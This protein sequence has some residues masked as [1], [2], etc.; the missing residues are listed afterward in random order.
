LL[1]VSQLFDNGRK[2]V[3]SLTYLSVAAVNGV[4]S[5]RFTHRSKV[6]VAAKSV[7]RWV[8]ENAPLRQIASLDASRTSTSFVPPDGKRNNDH[9]ERQSKMESPD[10]RKFTSSARFPR[11]TGISDRW[12]SMIC[13][14]AV[15]GD[16]SRQGALRFHKPTW[17]NESKRDRSEHRGREEMCRRAVE[18]D[19][20]PRRQL[21]IGVN[22]RRQC[23]RDG[24][25]TVGGASLGPDRLKPREES[26]VGRAQAV[27][28][29]D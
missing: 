6:L 12:S 24:G 20:S 4:E 15:L 7:C 5:R 28:S 17:I 21:A 29:T 2:A 10:Y 23:C 16:R 3:C 25:R 11:R 8:A 13:A 22:S 18:D 27:G 9:R 19:P 1:A 14:L 26:Q